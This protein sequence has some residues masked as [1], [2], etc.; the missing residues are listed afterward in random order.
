[1]VWGS[2]EKFATKPTNPQFRKGIGD[3]VVLHITIPNPSKMQKLTKPSKRPQTAQLPQ[4]IH[5]VWFVGIVK[6]VVTFVTE[7]ILSPEVLD[8]GMYVPSASP[9]RSYAPSMRCP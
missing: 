8:G 5:I 3:V 7:K 4:I 1:M 6:F 2:L 9:F